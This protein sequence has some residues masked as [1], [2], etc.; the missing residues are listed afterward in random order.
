METRIKESPAINDLTQAGL[1]TLT[2]ARR[3]IIVFFEQGRYRP[4][5]IFVHDMAVASGAPIDQIFPFDEKAPDTS[6]K[7]TG[8]NNPIQRIIPVP[9]LYYLKQPE[10]EGSSF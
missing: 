3:E 2:I 8:R 7:D 6:R 10:R 5:L 1:S 9:C 4:S